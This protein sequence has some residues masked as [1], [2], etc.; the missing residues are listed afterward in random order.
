MWTGPPAI[1]STQTIPSSSAL[2]ANM[3]PGTQ[4]PIAYMLQE[5]HFNNYLLATDAIILGYV[6]L[7]FRGDGYSIPIVLLNS[8]LFKSQV[9]D[10]WS[11][12]DTHQQYIAIQLL[13]QI[14][15][16]IFKLMGKR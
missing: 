10:V 13:T 15:T 6:C 16:N 14:I 2:W 1:P 9:F 4:S 11:T 8:Q 12:T 7:E 3:G 5:Q